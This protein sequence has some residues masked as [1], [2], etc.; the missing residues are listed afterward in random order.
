VFP[1][2]AL[3]R[4]CSSGRSSSRRYRFCNRGCE[5]SLV[6]LGTAAEAV[7]AEAEAA[8][9]WYEARG[10]CRA[11]CMTRQ[12]CAWGCSIHAMPSSNRITE[13]IRRGLAARAGSRVGLLAPES[14]HGRP[15]RSDQTL[16]DQLNGH[17]ALATS[18][19]VPVTDTLIWMAEGPGCGTDAMGEPLHVVGGVRVTEVEVMAR[20]VAG[21]NSQLT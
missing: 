16:C 7:V 6:E 20:G 18:P 12:P 15:R 21:L 19:C 8:D 13:A 5:L 11:S 1:T 10:Y 14:I 2:P 3:S 9:A 17:Q 4:R